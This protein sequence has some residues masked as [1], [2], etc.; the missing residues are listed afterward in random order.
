MPD[1]DFTIPTLMPI[2]TPRENEELEPPMRQNFDVP[3]LM[4]IQHPKA[5]LYA[6]ITYPEPD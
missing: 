5:D 3:G 2:E 1:P 4:Q 6:S